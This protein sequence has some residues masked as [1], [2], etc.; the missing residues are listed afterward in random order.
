MELAS[1]TR[2]DLIFFQLPGAN[3]PEVLSNFAARLEQAGVVEN[4]QVLH[5]RLL[6]R[7]ELCSTGIGSGIAIPHCKFKK[8]K[9]PVLAV[10]TSARPIDF[11]ALDGK[12]VQV[13]FL[14]ISPEDAP[15]EH[16]QVLSGLSKWIKEDP[17]AIDRIREAESAAAVYRM[18]GGTEEVPAP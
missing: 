13:F 16:L 15:A 4:A 9:R 7:E 5:R 18:L 8:L 10:A 17:S 3:G 2:K 12:P 14:L 11:R 1:Y 6:E